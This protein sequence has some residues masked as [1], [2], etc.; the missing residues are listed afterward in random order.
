[1]RC[2]GAHADAREPMLMPPMMNA[3]KY[4]YLISN[5][6]LALRLILL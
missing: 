5:A 4:F 3:A 1:M 6:N 2:Q